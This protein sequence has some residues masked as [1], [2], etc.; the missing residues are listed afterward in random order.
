V[1]S[2]LR[3]LGFVRPHLHLFAAAA[4]ATFAYATL[5][6]FAYI[7]LIPFVDALFNAP[8]G[9]GASNGGG[10]LEALLDRTVYRWVDRSGDPLDAIQGVILLLLA[11][12][13]AK[14]LF[15]FA[16]N[17][18]VARSEQSVTRDVRNQ[19]Y[20][21]LLRRNLA[22]FGRTRTGQIASRL[23]HDVEL[24][25][26]VVTREL[27]RASSAVLELGVA[28][29]AMLLISWRLTAAA[30][31]V[32][33]LT[34]GVWGPL[35]HRLRRGDR[36]VLHLAGEVSAHVHETVAGI[37][38]VK[39]SSAE[40]L[41]RRRFEGL[42][43]AYF[44]TY[45]RTERLR[46]LAA[47]LTELLATAGTVVILWY[48]ARLVVVE[49][50]LS[51]A[52]FVG[53][54][55]LSLKLFAP[56][57]YLARF[58][59][60]VQ[61]GLAAGDRVLEFLDVPAGTG[62][63]TGGERCPGVRESV[64]FRDVSFEYRAGDPVL[65]NVSFRVPA[66]SLVAVVGPSGAGKTTL[67]DLLGRFHDEYTGE[68][69][70][71]GMELRRVAVDSLRRDLGIVSQDTVVFHDTVRA[72][73]AYGRPEATSAEIEEA[74]RI[75]H[76][77]EFARRLPRGYDTVVGEGGCELSGGE[78]QRLSIARAILRDPRIL[79]FDEAT[80]A[81]DSES[82]RLV[83]DALERICHGR[84]VFVVAH[85]LS[86]VRRAD[87]ILVIEDGRLVE[88]GRHEELLP[89][90]GLYARLHDLQFEDIRIVP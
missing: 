90:G 52:A 84:T 30:F 28:L 69:L 66:G 31:V 46:A 38:L 71:D 39:T 33:P 16:R 63:V 76:V 43:G 60:L 62:E 26:A 35:V 64:E 6:A 2:Y 14:N 17:L 80:S 50:D 77:D 75:A 34:M 20:G 3:I 7:L 54:L 55:G 37:R 73:I 27:A 36:R 8:R 32:V 65:R 4:V 57:K 49:G 85:R 58:P 11:V 61:P 21:A 13:V 1:G 29:A 9:A 87:T 18:L 15:D 56:M 70:L 22:Y 5:D 51:S 25:R 40:E 74:A 10:S 19:A 81:L 41:E 83:Q 47:P 45:L 79:I 59:A 88:E 86:T 44:D 67:V 12:F 68:I 42:T 78:R 23:I 89:Q 72:N 48:G 53:F 24:M 82:E